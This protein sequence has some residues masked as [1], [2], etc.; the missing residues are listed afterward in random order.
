[1][2]MG[3][4]NVRVVVGGGEFDNERCSYKSPVRFFSVICIQHTEASNPVVFFGKI[5]GSTGIMPAAFLFI[6][7]TN[8]SQ[9]DRKEC[10]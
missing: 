5:R 7:Y 1:M 3:R 2:G 6:R 9:L 10:G 4:G 8:C